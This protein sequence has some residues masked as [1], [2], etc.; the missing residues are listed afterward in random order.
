MVS[1][2]YVV[3]PSDKGKE[4]ALDLSFI[5][6]SLMDSYVG[7]PFCFGMVGYGKP[8]QIDST[9]GAEAAIGRVL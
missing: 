5:W 1:G 6:I 4:A 9:E 2:E 8:S 3:P 7:S